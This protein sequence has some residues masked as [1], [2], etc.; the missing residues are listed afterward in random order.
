V[1]LPRRGHHVYNGSA[2]VNE[3]L[4]HESEARVN[5]LTYSQ[6][7]TN[8]AWAKTGA[9]T[10]AIDE[11]G[12]D[13]QTSAVT[14]VDS[15]GG[16]TGVTYVDNTVSV[17]VSTVYTFSVFA[18]ADQLSWL[19]IALVNFTSPA[20]G[21]AYFDLSTGTIGATITTTL[22]PLIEDF[23]NGWYRCS[24]TFTTDAVDTSGSLRLYVA[25]GNNDPVVDRDGTSSILIYGAQFEAGSTPSSY[26]PNAGATSGVT[27]AAETL[28]VPAANLPWP[29]PVVIGEELVTN[30]TFDDASALSD[31]DANL[32]TPS[33]VSGELLIENDGSGSGMFQDFPTEVGKVYIASATARAGTATAIDLR[34]Y[35]GGSFGTLLASATSA[36]TS[37]IFFEVVFTATTTSSRVYLRGAT[38]GGTSFW[39]NASVKE[40]NP[41]SVSIQMQG[42]MTYADTD[43]VF[44]LYQIRWEADVNNRIL[45]YVGTDG[46]FEGNQKFQQRAAAV[47]DLVSD[48]TAYS[49]GVN[50]PYNIASRHGSTFI[51]GAVDGVAL[52]VDPTPTALPDL[53]ATDL[54]LGYDYMGTIKLFR[55]WSNDLADDGIEIASGA[56]IILGIPTIGVS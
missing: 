12:P 45:H 4:L 53:S 47:L 54:E 48:T 35:T 44:E 20:S 19:H 32:A 10:L 31:W 25:D 30:G 5:L 15:G 24:V 40:I 42:R 7:F 33:V 29:S 41:L 17:S 22:T 56:P 2:W 50:V 23:G 9:A 39:D 14:L 8:A 21:G 1:Y 37:N 49:P 52:T 18:K 13:G 26:I 28:T 36:S 55:M 38:L 3:G 11:T 6:D 43:D 16:G 51:N 34:V 27:R 46:A